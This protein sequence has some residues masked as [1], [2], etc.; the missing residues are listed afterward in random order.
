N[1]ELGATH[2]IY[3]VGG[4]QTLHFT[5]VF[6]VLELMDKPWANDCRHVAFGMM[7]YNGERL[8]TRKGKIVYLE[9]VLQRAISE[10]QSIIDN[11]NPS[12]P[13]K[14][15][16]AK[17]VG[18]GAVVFNDLKSYRMHDVD[19]K[20]EEVL[21]FDGETGPYVQYTHARAS[22]VLRKAEAAGL[23]VPAATSFQA[24]SDSE[25][26]LIHLM[27]QADEIFERAVDDLDPSL[28]ARFALDI[29][30]AFNR[31]YHDEPILIAEP[32][33]RNP[34]LALTEATKSVLA[35]S[36]Y[37]LGLAAPAAM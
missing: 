30:H 8:S 31:F 32:A 23:S 6:K 18:I 27:N 36:L 13:D 34:R 19:F 11:K 24:L 37:L 14:E 26:R 10:A 4:E 28:I 21:N 9:D 25:W 7:K 15:E 16:V 29:C 33:Y 22:S 12:L 3:V 35:T 1:R 2:L 20:Y 5:Q 17:A